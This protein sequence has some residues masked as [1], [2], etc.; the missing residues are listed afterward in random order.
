MYLNAIK[1]CRSIVQCDACNQAQCQRQIKSDLLFFA[2]DPLAV[3]IH[4]YHLRILD[5]IRN[6]RNPCVPEPLRL[7]LT[8]KYFGNYK[9]NDW[10]NARQMHDNPVPLFE[11]FVI[12]IFIVF[13]SKIDFAGRIRFAFY[14]SARR[15]NDRKIIRLNFRHGLCCL[16]LTDPL[17]IA[18]CRY[19]CIAIMIFR[20]HFP[21]I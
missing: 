4:T 19:N 17:I 12:V 7:Q 1:R 9:R 11:F 5:S 18:R 13:A 20:F 6:N 21:N 8:V 2:F 10:A 3:P 16:Q 15:F 14:A